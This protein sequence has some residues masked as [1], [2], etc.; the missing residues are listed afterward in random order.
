MKK[1]VL[2]IVL[3]FS[4]VGNAIA[5][6]VVQNETTKVFEYANIKEFTGDTKARIDL[7][8]NKF[9][10]LNYSNISSS[11]NDI[12]G[13]SFFTKIIMGTS[14]EVHYQV[15]IQFKE[16]KYKIIINKFVIKDQ[17]YGA[18]PIENIS[19]SSQKRWL[20]YINENLPTIIKNIESTE[21]W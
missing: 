11:E 10:E 8:A 5:Q 2:F 18:T 6:S 9:K 3:L 17:R 1:Q 12:K 7:F 16:N 19:K 20:E 4:I 15:F 14:M 21:T 13:E